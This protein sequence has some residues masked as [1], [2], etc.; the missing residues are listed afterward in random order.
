MPEARLHGVVVTCFVGANHGGNLKYRKSRT[1]VLIF[2]NKSPIHW[3]SESQT[4]VEASTFG[5]ELCAMNTAVEIVE[6]LR[7]KLR[8]FG[9]PVEVPSNVHCDNEA[10]TK[11]TKIPQSTLKKK[12]HSISYHMCRKEVASGTFRI[13]KQGKE[14]NIANLFTKILTAGRREFLLE[15]ITY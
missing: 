8:M 3:Y 7:Y 15:I 10:L 2:I 12:H 5:A 4:T 14:K 11:N 9:I 1:G 6:A 13:T